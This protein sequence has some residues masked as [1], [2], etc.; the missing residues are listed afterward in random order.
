M[1]GDDT[2]D[3]KVTEIVA[4]LAPGCQHRDLDVV[5]DGK[6]QAGA[7]GQPLPLVAVDDGKAAMV[8]DRGPQRSHLR[9]RRCAEARDHEP[10]VVQLVCAQLGQHV[11][12]LGGD[13]VGGHLQLLIA[14]TVQQLQPDRNR[15]D[16]L[17]VEH[18]RRQIIARPHDVADT[19]RTVDRHARGLQRRDVAIDGAGGDL[20]RLGKLCGGH[21]PARAAQQVNQIEEP[22]RATHDRAPPSP[23]SKVRGRRIPDGECLPLFMSGI[24][25]VACRLSVYGTSARPTTVRRRMPRCDAVRTP[26]TG[27]PVM[28]ILRTIPGLAGTPGGA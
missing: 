13:P 28:A 3:A 4:Q 5:D 26:A 10:A 15:L 8:A 23:C 25:N 11:G 19:G 24:S 1:T 6:R 7:L 9:R 21:R 14:S 20:Q 27:H 2:V 16:L 17:A 12:D 18:Q 22:V